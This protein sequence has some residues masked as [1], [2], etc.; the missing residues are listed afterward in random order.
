[1][2]IA[3]INDNSNVFIRVL[4]NWRSTSLG[5]YLSTVWLMVRRFDRQGTS[6]HCFLLTTTTARRKSLGPT[7]TLVLYYIKI[8]R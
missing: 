8:R 5:A 6:P 1:M 4:L 7:G 2:Y 3:A